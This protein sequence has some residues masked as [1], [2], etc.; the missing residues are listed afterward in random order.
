MLEII[1]ASKGSV[2][3]VKDSGTSY[4]SVN[5]CRVLQRTPDERLGTMP[6]DEAISAG[7]ARCPNCHW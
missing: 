6:E 2:L 7:L 1:D 3:Y 5:G 4:H